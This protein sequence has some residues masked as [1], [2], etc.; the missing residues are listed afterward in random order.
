MNI[1]HVCLEHPLYHIFH[2]FD[3][4]PGQDLVIFISQSHLSTSKHTPIAVS[5]QVGV[6]PAVLVI[7][8]LVKKYLSQKGKF[9]FFF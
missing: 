1:I 7:D 5:P 9:F 2:I 3:Q 6:S 8:L 4:P